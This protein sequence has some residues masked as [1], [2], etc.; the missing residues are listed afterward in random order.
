TLIRYPETLE[1]AASGSAPH[2]IAQY[3][4]ELAQAFHTYYHAVPLLVEEQ[5]L[6]NARLSLC[7]AT[8]LILADG[9]S[10][11]GVSAPSKM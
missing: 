8:R 2:L 10:L 6:R 5:A 1:Q 7:L 4:R 11:L 9:L 3:L